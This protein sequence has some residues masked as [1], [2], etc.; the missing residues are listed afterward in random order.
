M[1]LCNYH[2][3]HTFVS[4]KTMFHDEKRHQKPLYISFKVAN[5]PNSF[6]QEEFYPRKGFLWFIEISTLKELFTL[7]KGDIS[8]IYERWFQTL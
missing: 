4:F 8:L 1:M 2:N 7:T 5:S 3:Q 6:T